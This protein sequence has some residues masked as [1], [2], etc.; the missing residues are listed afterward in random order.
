MLLQEPRCASCYYHTW[1]LGKKILA[2]LKFTALDYYIQI[3]YYYRAKTSTWHAVSIA[4][5]SPIIGLDSIP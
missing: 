1:V 2:S 5:V 4:L 3:V